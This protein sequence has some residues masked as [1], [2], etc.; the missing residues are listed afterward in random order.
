MINKPRFQLG[1]H[2][3]RWTR[4]PLIAPILKHGVIIEIPKRHVNE[5]R[6]IVHNYKK[7][8]KLPTNHIRIYSIN[9]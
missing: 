1:S 6:K 3:F 2:E 7:Q 8:N 5:F 9:E 4:W